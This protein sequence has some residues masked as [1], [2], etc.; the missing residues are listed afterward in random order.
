ML[1]Q[2]AALFDSN[3]FLDHSANSLHLLSYQ[4]N[5]HL[6]DTQTTTN[7]LAKALTVFPSPAFSLSLALLPPYTTPY[8]ST[9]PSSENEFVASVQKLTTLSTLLESAQYTKFWAT[10]K[11]DDHQV[12]ADCTADI[13]GFE[14]LIRV[15]IATQAG[16]AFRTIETEVLKSW[17]DLADDAAV[18]KF[19]TDVCGWTVDKSGN[20]PLVQIPPNK[21]NEARG[22]VKSEKV[23]IEQFGRIIR[24]GF[25]QPV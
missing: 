8:D 2:L 21:E 6:L 22:E 7:I 1:L 3:S 14:E 16:R 5:P 25:E 9:S 18:E 11:G 10:Y 20:A 15:R 24:R 13:N 4:F 23:G 19:V 17:L 12:Y